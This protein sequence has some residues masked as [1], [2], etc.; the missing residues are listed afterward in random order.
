MMHTDKTWAQEQARLVR[1]HMTLTG[2]YKILTEYRKIEEISSPSRLK[3]GEI[4]EK[5]CATILLHL[6]F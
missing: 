6:G 4:T 2:Y 1:G 3:P 5:K